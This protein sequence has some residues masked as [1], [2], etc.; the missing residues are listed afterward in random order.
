MTQLTPLALM[1]MG[2]VFPGGAAAEVDPGH[3]HISGLHFVNEVL[4]DVLHAVGGQLL[5]VRGVQIAGGDDHVGVHVVPVFMDG[6]LYVH[7]QTSFSCFA[8]NH[9]E[10]SFSSGHTN[11]LTALHRS[12]T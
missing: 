8:N 5:V 6:S 9:E 2:G 11:G 1:A 12:R 10:F 4:V 3:H 7:V